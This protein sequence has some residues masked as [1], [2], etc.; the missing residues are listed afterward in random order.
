MWV[1][2]HIYIVYV[3]IHSHTSVHIE[4][5]IKIHKY[6]P[7]PPLHLR[8]GTDVAAAMLL[9]VTR[10]THINETCCHACQHTRERVT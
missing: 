1:H 7:L 10:A 9:N 5:Y 4:A 6:V 8:S 3:Y 2:I